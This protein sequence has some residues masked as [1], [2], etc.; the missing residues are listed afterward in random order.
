MSRALTIRMPRFESRRVLW[1]AA[2][3][4]VPGAL[5]AL[6]AGGITAC[7]SVLAG[8]AICSIAYLSL[9]WSLRGEGPPKPSALGHLAGSLGRT[10]F[11]GVPAVLAA[12]YGGIPGGAGFLAGLVIVKVSVLIE[13]VRS[14]R[15]A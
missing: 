7:V 12:V 14:H 8:T 1:N 9:A 5:V 13:G 11:V 15:D 10:T 4:G 2:A 3:L 6:P